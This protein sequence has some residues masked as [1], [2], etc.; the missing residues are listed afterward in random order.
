MLVPGRTVTAA[1]GPLSGV[2]LWFGGTCRSCVAS[3]PC[4]GPNEGGGSDLSV[5]G[6]ALIDHGGD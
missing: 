5:D 1:A 2:P 3:E 6:F 4:A